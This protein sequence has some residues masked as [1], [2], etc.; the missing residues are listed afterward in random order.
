MRAMCSVMGSACAARPPAKGSL[1]R[2]HEP[3][4]ESATPAPGPLLAQASGFTLLG[5]LAEGPRPPTALNPG[6]AGVPLARLPVNVSRKLPYREA[7]SAG[8]TLTWG[9]AS[10]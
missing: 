1:D 7:L 5:C 9:L 10:S 2:P 6:I 3:R 4:G 8:R